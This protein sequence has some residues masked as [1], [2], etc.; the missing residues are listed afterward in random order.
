MPGGFH[1]QRS[2]VGYRPWV[3]RQSDMTEQLTLSHFYYVPDTVVFYFTYGPTSYETRI[4]IISVSQTRKLRCRGVEQLAQ[5]HPAGR[6]KQWNQNLSNL[7]LK[8]ACLSPQGHPSQGTC[9]PNI[10]GCDS[11]WLII[12]QERPGQQSRPGQPGLLAHAPGEIVLPLT[13]TCVLDLGNVAL[14]CLESQRGTHGSKP[15]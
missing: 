9:Q 8:S 1:G 7:A 6:W 12:C 15:A 3:R 5:G 2:L 14:G 11:R 10:S 4:I 13:G